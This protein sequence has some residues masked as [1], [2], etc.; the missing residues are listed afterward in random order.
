MCRQLRE[1]W[2]E[3]KDGA[4]RAGPVS[5]VEEEDTGHESVPCA[6]VGVAANRDRRKLLVRRQGVCAPEAVRHPSEPPKVRGSEEEEE[7]KSRQEESRKNKR[8]AKEKKGEEKNETGRDARE[9]ATIINNMR[10]AG[11]KREVG[12]FDERRTRRYVTNG[13]ASNKEVGRERCGRGISGEGVEGETGESRQWPVWIIPPVR[14]SVEKITGGIQQSVEVGVRGGRSGT[15]GILFASAD[16]LLGRHRN[17]SGKDGRRE[18]DVGRAF[19]MVEGRGMRS[20]GR[21]RSAGVLAPVESSSEAGMGE[22]AP[23][24]AVEE[25]IP[26]VSGGSK[27]VQQVIDG[28]EIAHGDAADGD[29]AAEGRRRCDGLGRPGVRVQSPVNPGR[30][31]KV[32]QISNKGKVVPDASAVFRF[33]DSPVRFHDNGEPS[34]EIP[35]DAARGRSGMFG[36]RGEEVRDSGFGV[37]RRFVVDR[38]KKSVGRSVEEMGVASDGGIGLVLGFEERVDSGEQEKVSGVDFG[39]QRKSGPSPGK[40]DQADQARG[41]IHIIERKSGSGYCIE[42]GW[43]SKS[44]SVGHTKRPGDSM[45]NRSNFSCSSPRAVEGFVELG[46]KKVERRVEVVVEGESCGAQRGA[47]VPMAGGQCQLDVKA[48][49]GLARGEMANGRC[50]VDQSRSEIR[51]EGGIGTITTRYNPALGKQSVASGSRGG[52]P[53]AGSVRSRADRST[54]GVGVGQQRAG[55][56]FQQYAN[57]GPRSVGGG[58]TVVLP[59]QRNRATQGIVDTIK[60]NGASGGRSA[61]AAGGRKRLDVEGGDIREDLDVGPRDGSG[62]VRNRTEREA[63]SVEQS[64]SRTG[65]RSGG[66]VGTGLDSVSQLCVRAASDARASGG[67]VVVAGSTRSGA[68]AE[69]AGKY[70]VAAGVSN[71]AHAR[72]V[73]VS[74]RTRDIRAGPVRESFGNSSR[75]MGILGGQNQLAWPREVEELYRQAVVRMSGGL[76]AATLK[77]YEREMDLFNEWR[78]KWRMDK[79]LP[80]P[81]WHVMAYLEWITQTRGPG[82]ASKVLSSIE[83]IHVLR[84]AP[85]QKDPLLKQMA[86]SLKKQ[87]MRRRNPEKVS[88]LPVEAIM[89]WAN[90]VKKEKGEVKLHRQWLVGLVLGVRAIK[91]SADMVKVKIGHVKSRVGG[92]LTVYFPDTKNHPEGEMVPI[93]PAGIAASICPVR[94]LRDWVEER[95]KDGAKDDDWLF[96]KAKGVQTVA[97]GHKR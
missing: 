65:H 22:A 78:V 56:S 74:G 31:S 7:Q 2:K 68:S 54:G 95:K 27:D 83:K 28:S 33:S 11:E 15:G 49:L 96:T 85:M 90:K 9:E 84:Q 42:N 60:R 70:L 64:V 26:F 43:K 72:A 39:R 79:T 87:S 3:E 81:T 24:I 4:D 71:G 46:S 38:V 16:Q 6:S 41:A 17:Q 88:E 63:S 20:S 51:T 21:E 37:Y 66:R 57:R 61:V 67:A 91:R 23:R 40:K 14:R 80:A 62:P 69:L 75:A 55:G 36:S 93:E 32:V 97:S 92:G 12:G 34:V 82:V 45:G 53:W 5:C 10:Y 19:E 73:D 86:D 52:P 29:S 59:G 30:L 50:I 77:S 48:Q 58:G 76:K 18:M 47:S 8:Y 35:S 25:E 1:S 44:R 89:A 13:E 94:L